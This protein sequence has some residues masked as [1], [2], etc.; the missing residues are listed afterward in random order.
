MKY[1]KLF[2]VLLSFPTLASAAAPP[3]TDTLPAASATWIKAHPVIVAATYAEGY[4]PFEVVRD[5]HVEGLAADYLRELAEDLGTAV[6]FQIFPDW[7]SALAAAQDGEVDVLMD[8]APTPDRNGKLLIGAPYYESS[9]MLAVRREESAIVHFGDLRGRRVATQA[10]YAEDQVLKRYVP[11]VVVVREATIADALHQL[12]QGGVDAVLG[13]PRVLDVAMGRTGLRHQL[14]LGPT[15]PLPITTLSF[16]V[17]TERGRAPLLTALDHALNRLKPADHARLRR[18]WTHDGPGHFSEDLDIPLS[19]DER[20]WLATLPPLR[21]GIDPTAAP[22]TLLDRDGR[23]EGMAID[24]L[25]D[26]THALGI[27]TETVPAANWDETTRRAMSGEI[28]LLPAASPRNSDLGR[29]FD[30]S[31]PYATFPVMIVTREDAPTVVSADDLAGRRI[32]ANLVRPAVAQAAAQIAASETIPVGSTHE[33]LQAVH[34]GR[35]DAFVGDIASTEYLLR[36]DYPGRLKMTAS[37]GA[38]DDLSIAIQRRYAP[39]LPLIDRVLSRMPDRRAEAIR[40]T[41]LR[42]EYTWGGSWREI[43]RKAWL[44]G[45]LA[46]SLFLAMTLAYFRLRRETRRRLR[47]EEQL[48][49]V[50]R[51]IPAVVYRYLYHDDGRIE[52]TYVGGNPEPIFGVGTDTF[53]HDERSAFARIDPRDQGPL[54]ALIASA[55]MTLSAVHTEM[56]IR[57]SQP[58]RWIAAHAVPR[59]LGSLVEF[60]GYWIDVSEQHLQ[61]AQLA[62]A[63]EAAERATLAKSHFLATMSHEIRTPMHGV[64]GM[65]EMLADTPLTAE[66]RRLLGTAEHSADALMQIVDDVLDFSRIEA[67]CLVVEPTPVDLR[68]LA[69]GIMDLFAW[70]AERKALLLNCHIDE[71]LAPAHSVDGMRL[72]QVLL[73]LVSNAVKFTPD[74]Q[75]DVAIDVIDDGPEQQRLRITVADTGIGIAADDLTHLFAPFQQAESSTTRRFGGSGLGLTISRRLVEL[76][77]GSVT[78]ESQPGRGTCVTVMLELACCAPAPPV[79]TPQPAVSGT[80]YVLN[81][82]VAEDHP[83]NRELICTQ[84]ERLGHRHRVV[85][86]GRQALA[87]ATSER[88]D[89]LL[90]DLHMPGLDGYTL[91]RTLR[92]NGSDLHIVAMTA[93]A[94]IGEREHCSA[95]GMDDFLSKPVRIDTLR[96]ALDRCR[97]EEPSPWDTSHL[98]ETFGS[99][100]VLSSL[101]DRFAHATQEDLEKARHLDDPASMAETI[102]RILGGM[103]IFGT[104]PEAV[105][106]ET[107][108]HALKSA[109][110]DEAMARVPAFLA[111]VSAWTERLRRAT[112]KADGA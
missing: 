35:V 18:T 6:R 16:A 86:D 49:D 81:V 68:A 1:L 62:A 11:D 76:L 58:I 23:V 106:G 5:G 38:R 105:M 50:T 65:L 104:S 56:R 74:G 42:S 9:S 2:V 96:R 87:L 88:F 15:A 37:T 7:P 108:E 73:N 47:T 75:V 71:R 110:P 85:P 39:L 40:N 80:Q 92:D 51:N 12:A 3:S 13:D 63:K 67:G 48:A 111:S 25:R 57:D 99:L 90:T 59:R 107:I 46:M 70:Q 91:A 20:A 26:I 109:T 30:F 93:N 94:M 55:A 21:I 34:S 14:R 66:Q 41:W 78:L 72:R 31:T 19:A 103:R 101:V 64:I 112:A 32:A 10:G 17:A 22:I 97:P 52:F 102:H 100:D 95:I 36:R 44:P 27:R 8:V 28:D 77:D 45:V 79:A 43:A 69:E 33:G 29:Q 61:S 4:A 83:T 24:Y 82:L 89:V 84:L 60:T 53:L 98:L 54:E